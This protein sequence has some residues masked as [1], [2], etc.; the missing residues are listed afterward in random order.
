MAESELNVDSLIARLLEGELPGADRYRHPC[1]IC[2]SRSSLF[3]P[4]DSSRSTRNEEFKTTAM[5]A[6]CFL[7]RV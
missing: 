6:D 7:F 1:K 3:Y 2:R 4:E 5:I